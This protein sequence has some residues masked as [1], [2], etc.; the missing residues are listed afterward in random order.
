MASRV[1]VQVGFPVV[2]AGVL[3]WYLLFKF[4][5]NVEVITA[6][7]AANTDM[8]AKLVAFQEKMVAAQENEFLELHKQTVVLQEMSERMNKLV[9]SA[10]RRRPSPPQEGQ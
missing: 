7:M 8:A 5:G 2:V 9:A 1:I 4:T 10:E 6:R 3:L